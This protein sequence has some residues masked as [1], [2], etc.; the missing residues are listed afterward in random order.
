MR[1]QQP[2]HRGQT[3]G[4]G[5]QGAFFDQLPDQ[6]LNLEL[7]I[8]LAQLHDGLTGLRTEGLAR[9]PVL[10]RLALERRETLVAEKIIPFLQSGGRIGFVAP[11]PVRWPEPWHG[12]A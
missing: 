1:R 7:G 11:G 4:A 8:L 9:A 12:P 6:H 2:V 3:E 10:T 5:L